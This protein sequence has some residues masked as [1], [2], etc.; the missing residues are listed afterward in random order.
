MVKHK[1]SW[2]NAGEIP[3]G[4]LQEILQ[5]CMEKMKSV[6][7]SLQALYVCS[8]SFSSVSVAEWPP[9]GKLVYTQLTIC[10]LSISNIC[11]I[12]YFL[13]WFWVL[14][15]SGPDLCIIFTFNAKLS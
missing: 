13:F 12:S 9:F 7:L 10:S 6:F 3:P 1:I 2:R 8:Y 11:N 4:F 15:A 14:I 5:L